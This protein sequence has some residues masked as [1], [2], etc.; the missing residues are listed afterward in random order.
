VRGEQPEDHEDVAVEVRRA[1]GAR[2]RVVMEPGPLYVWPIQW[3]GVSSRA[4]VSRA[5]PATNRSTTA[6]ARRAATRSA[7]WPAAATVV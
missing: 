2:R 1:G 7:R 3:C 5:E 6:R 4:R